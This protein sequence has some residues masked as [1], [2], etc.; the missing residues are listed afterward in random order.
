[1][2]LKERLTVSRKLLSCD[3][4]GIRGI[5][6]IEILSRIEEELRTINGK[7]KL[8]LA[9]YFDYVAGTSTGAIIATLV[10]LGYSTDAIREFLR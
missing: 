1:M 10:A 4:G 6:S 3:G 8:V 5:I 9:D 7:P 2:N